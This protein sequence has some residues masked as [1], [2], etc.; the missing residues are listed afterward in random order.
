LVLEKV[1]G[2]RHERVI[3]DCRKVA[4]L[5]SQTRTGEGAGEG[6]ALDATLEV[7]SRQPPGW[8]QQVIGESAENHPGS[9]SFVAH[10]TSCREDARPEPRAQAV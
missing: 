5:G 4:A 2:R 9:E 1:G 7:G 6:Q 8:P 3:D 10:T